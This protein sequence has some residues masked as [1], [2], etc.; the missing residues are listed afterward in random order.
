MTKAN[1]KGRGKLARKKSVGPKK[2][3]RTAA[4]KTADSA[5]NRKTKSDQILAL[6]KQPGGA[7][8]KAIMAATSWQ[9]HS[10]RGFISG[11]LVKKMKHRVKSSRRDGERVYAVNG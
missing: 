6:M 5:G 9:A 4:K 8:L 1:K 11:H 7:T 3:P 2:T 10:V